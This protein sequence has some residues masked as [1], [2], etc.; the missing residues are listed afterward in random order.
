MAWME[1]SGP[2]TADKAEASITRNRK[3]NFFIAPL[4]YERLFYSPNKTQFK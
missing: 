3:K 2:V 1:Y 4:L